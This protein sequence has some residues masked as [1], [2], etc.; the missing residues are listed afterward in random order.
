MRPNR[1]T[2]LTLA[3]ALAAVFV[4]TAAAEAQSRSRQLIIKKRSFLD[5][6]NVVPVGS[7]SRYVTDTIRINRTPDYYAQRGRYGLETLPGPF[8]LPGR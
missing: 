2:C 3:A 1:A 4:S 8:E 5:T 6:G 7:Q